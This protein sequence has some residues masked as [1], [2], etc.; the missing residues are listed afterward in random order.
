MK[1]TIFTRSGFGVLIFMLVIFLGIAGGVQA[2]TIYVGPEGDYDSISAAVNAAVSGD[3]II[4]A[5]GTYGEVT[6][7]KHVHIKSE[8]GPEVTR[9]I[10]SGERGVIFTSD[11]NSSS[12][13]GFYIRGTSYGVRIRNTEGTLDLSDIELKN[14]ILEGSGIYGIYM[15]TNG[16][17]KD[18]RNITIENNVISGNGSDGI[19]YT[20][21]SYGTDAY[22]RDSVIHNNIIVNNQGYG[23]VNNGY[24]TN[25]SILNNNVFNNTSGVSSG[26]TISSSQGNIF[27]DPL[28]VSVG[29]G[30]YNLRSDSPCIDSGRLG[31]SFNDPD[32]TR[33]NMGVYGGPGAASFWPSPAGGPVV[34]DLQ[35][36]PP[37]VPSGGTI[38]IRATGE[39]R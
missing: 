32:G 39:I 2:G 20:G 35:V 8:E 25:I 7:N 3:D 6:V 9:I 37:S 38:T 13:D 24:S 36:T 17:G 14:N 23:I 5:P 29:T 34:T 1:Q 21:S 12:I 15:N 33:N 22:V 18:I 11:G 10:S 31:A 26:V 27:T 19:W 16:S 4:V 30:N 28:F